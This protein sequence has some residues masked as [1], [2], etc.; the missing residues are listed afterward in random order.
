[1]TETGHEV[2]QFGT[3]AGEGEVPDRPGA[4]GI[5]IA[6]EKVFVV[7][8]RGKYFLPGGGIEPGVRPEAALR[9]EILEETGHEVLRAF[10]LVVANQYAT[11]LK[12]GRFVNKRCC[13][14]KVGLGPQ[15][16]HPAREHEPLWLDL[17]EVDL[18]LEEEAS[19]WAIHLAHGSG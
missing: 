8:W 9:R 19:A 17:A 15:T 1:M 11:H 2:R 5:T 14:F 13:F 16:G 12:S 18:L 6:E 7:R 3:P 10:P 4:Y